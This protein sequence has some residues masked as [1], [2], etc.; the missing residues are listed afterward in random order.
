M[1]RRPL[2]RLGWRQGPSRA[3]RFQSHL[4]LRTRPIRVLQRRARNEA[5]RIWSRGADPYPITRAGPVMMCSA[6]EA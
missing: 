3:P 6:G 2:S 4:Y 5:L 1:D